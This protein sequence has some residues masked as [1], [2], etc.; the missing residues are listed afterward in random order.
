MKLW[1]GILLTGLLLLPTTAAAQERP[2]HDDYGGLF[3]VA[4]AEALH[5]RWDYVKGW[6]GG[7]LT[8]Y[9][10]LNIHKLFPLVPVRRS[11]P[12]TALVEAPRSDIANFMVNTTDRGQ[13]TLDDYVSNDPRV[14]GFVVLHHGQ[15]VYERYINMRQDDR[16]IYFSVSKIR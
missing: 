12:V 16:H 9:A 2:E 10:N 4:E 8:R 15:L 6:F 14:D 11:G 13:V 3:S 5:D 7:E 1:D